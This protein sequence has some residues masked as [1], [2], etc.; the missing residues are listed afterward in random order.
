MA[1]AQEDEI[2]FPLDNFY[3]KRVK[4]PVRTVLHRI[5]FNASLGYG[6]T[7]MR[8]KL[9]GFGV[10]QADGVQ[11]LIF[12]IGRSNRYSN[13]VNT[14]RSDVSSPGPDSFIV[15]GDT[16][17]L[18]FKANALNIPFQLYAHY[19]FLDRIRIGGGISYEIMSMGTFSPR[20]F[21]DRIGSFKP[22][23]PLGF[24]RKYFGMLG[25]SFYRWNDIVFVGEANVG[26]YKPGN[27]F[28]QS[29]IQ[30]GVYVNVGVRAERELSEYLRA[31]ARASFEIKNYTLNVPGS[32]GGSIVHNLNAFYLNVGLSYRLPEL[33][34]CFHRLCHIQI[35]HAHGNKEY[36]SRMHSIFKKQNPHYGENYP[37]LLKY[38]GRNKKKLNPY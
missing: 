37:K 9:D 26:S 27:N 24:M 4:N 5:V 25:V 6:N 29:F 3:A 36:R 33:P 1:Y 2:T 17:Q 15:T 20:Y 8:H 16:V 23:N 10:A 13:W 22:T 14:V 19:E 12:P 31:F 34:R 21:S 28:A 35:N 11:P 38:K 30:K 7:F 18:G 32:N